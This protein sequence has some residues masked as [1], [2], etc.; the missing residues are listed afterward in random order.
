MAKKACAPAF[1]GHLAS[2]VMFGL[3]LYIN[4]PRL[5]APAVL[6]RQFG[7]LFSQLTSG[8]IWISSRRY[9]A[10]GCHLKQAEV[11]M[12]FSSPHAIPTFPSILLWEYSSTTS[13]LAEAR[14]PR[15]IPEGLLEHNN[16]VRFASVKPQKS[17]VS[18]AL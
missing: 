2:A 15:A 4:F 14:Q 1:F 17:R 6:A 10:G 18:L 5:A 7:L 12:P 11:C 13:S 8:T 3:R 9:I 16:T